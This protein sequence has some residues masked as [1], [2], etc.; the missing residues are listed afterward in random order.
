[1]FCF[2]QKT[3]YDMRMSD[4]SSDVCSSDLLLAKEPLHL[5]VLNRPLDEKE[6]RRPASPCQTAGFSLFRLLHFRDGK[7]PDRSE[8]RSVGKECVSTCRSRWSRFH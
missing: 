4:W 3:A 8:E 5:L 6:R 2:N 7:G 1:M